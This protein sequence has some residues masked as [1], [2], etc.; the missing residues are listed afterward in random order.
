MFRRLGETNLGDHG[1]HGAQGLLSVGVEHQHFLA[2]VA[3]Q[4]PARPER[5]HVLQT[6]K[7][8]WHGWD[9]VRRRGGEVPKEA[10]CVR[11]DQLD[12]PAV[13]ELSH[14]LLLLN[15]GVCQ[16]DDL[17]YKPNSKHTCRILVILTR[18]RG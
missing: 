16:H 2:K 11:D 13:A 15:A 18:I 5:Q 3:E 12:V 7:P 14:A 9:G 1:D 6:P 17:G 8:P 4:L 10:P